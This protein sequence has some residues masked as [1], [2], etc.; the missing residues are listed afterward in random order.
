MVHVCGQRE[1]SRL[2]DQDQVSV[3]VCEGWDR[4]EGARRGVR[5]RVVSVG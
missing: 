4:R 3:W 5:G 1:G 2:N